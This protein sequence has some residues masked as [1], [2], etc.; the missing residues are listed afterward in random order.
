MIWFSGGGN[1]DG[2]VADLVVFD[3]CGVLVIR[4]KG[5]RFKSGRLARQ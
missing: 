2:W 5:G 3:S 4:N 1:G